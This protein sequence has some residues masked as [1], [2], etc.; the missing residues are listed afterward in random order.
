MSSLNKSNPIQSG[1]VTRHHTHFGVI[2]MQIKVFK[3]SSKSMLVCDELCARF[4]YA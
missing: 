2:V 4:D 3:V 1:E